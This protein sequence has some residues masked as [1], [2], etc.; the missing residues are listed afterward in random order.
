MNYL[1]IR[2]KHKD[3]FLQEFNRIK[4]SINRGTTPVY[5]ELRGALT[6]LF[7]L[8]P[9][10]VI[11]SLFLVLSIYLLKLLNV[12][13]IW[14]VVI[15]L[16]INTT[17]QTLSNCILVLLKH[18]LRVKCLKRFGLEVNEKNISVLECMEYQSV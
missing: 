1:F 15:T 3:K 16:V 13:D 11:Q 2:K 5:S 10:L 17:I 6:N 9:F 14:L 18:L 8:L 4:E 7:E 12:N